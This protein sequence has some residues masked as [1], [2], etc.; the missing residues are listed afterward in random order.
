MPAIEEFNRLA[1][2]M[3]AGRFD[4]ACSQAVVFRQQSPGF[5]GAH[6]LM[7]LCDTNAGRLDKANAHFRAALR[8]RPDFVDSRVN[9]ANN[10]ARLGQLPLAVEEYRQ[11]LTR[12]PGHSGAKQNL[13]ALARLLLAGGQPA[14]AVDALAGLD[15]NAEWHTLAGYAEYKLG[16]AAPALEH[17]QKALELDPKLED[18]WLK[19]GEML[20]FY[21]S[22][23]AAVAYFSRGARELPESKPIRL[24]WAVALLATDTDAAKEEAL[25]H[26]ETLLKAD[27]HYEPALGVLCRV[28]QQRQQTKEL[29]KTAA[30]W[31]ARNPN[32]S[33]AHYYQAVA[34]GKEPEAER[35]LKEA[36]RLNPASFDAS[37]ALSKRLLQQGQ[38]QDAIA[39][40][41]RAAELRPADPQP[42]YLLARAWREA[43]DASRS[44]LALEAFQQRKSQEQPWSRLLFEL[45][46]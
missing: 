39:L 34:A 32:S 23:A 11:V 26:L 16:R 41:E 17:L 1:R 24:G 13:M 33:E 14:K 37:I 15:K 27:P 45:A 7:G 38:V 25:A 18:G 4:A 44:R 40:L 36:L 8:L 6:H 42:H 19:I 12:N 22:P 28:F 5:F 43:G 20:L 3:R 10:L 46:K 29:A 30:E 31:R 2:E 21:Q 9:L 35:W